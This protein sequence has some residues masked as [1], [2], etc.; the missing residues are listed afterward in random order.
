MKRRVDVLPRAKRQLLDA[1][2]W[3]ADRRS[4][5]EASRWLEGLEAAIESLTEDAERF[6]LAHESADFAFP[7]RQM[8]FGVSGHATHRVLFS[9]EDDRV[10]I[11]AVRHLAQQEVTPDDLASLSICRSLALTITYHASRPRSR[12]LTRVA[13]TRSQ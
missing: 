2:Q 9:V 7:L 10:L 13:R 1:A 6:T 11:Y 3:W 5:A 4:V 12:R 8:N